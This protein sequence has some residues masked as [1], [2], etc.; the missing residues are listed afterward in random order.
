MCL[1]CYG[2]AAQNGGFKLEDVA[3]AA[4][5]MVDGDL[6]MRIQTPRS[7]SSMLSQDP[8]DPWA[9]SDKYEVNHASFLAMKKTLTR[10][11][12]LCSSTCDVN[13]WTPVPKKP[14]LIQ[15]LIRTLNETSQFWPW[16]ALTQEMPTEMAGVLE[17]GRS[18]TVSRR[19]GIVSVLAPVKDSLG[20]IVGVVEVVSRVQP[21]PQENVQ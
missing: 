9:A 10:L 15:V 16:G 14:G 6:A 4:T 20:D 5:V 21:D 12:H 13:L 19:A 7:V 1:C 18:V 2:A 8:R 11:T 17:T 3:R